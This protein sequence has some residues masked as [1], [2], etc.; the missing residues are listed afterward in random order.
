MYFRLTC[1]FAYL[2]AT[3]AGHGGISVPGDLGRTHRVEPGQWFE[4]R[5][6]VNNGGDQPVVASIYQTDY[7]HSADGQTRYDPAPSHKRSNAG[8][9]TVTP[10]EMKLAAGESVTVT[11]QGQV[12][13]DITLEGSFWSMIMIEG[14]AVSESDADESDESA[15]LRIR[16]ITRYGI[17]IGTHIG[18]TGTRQLKILRRDL[19]K[20]D[21]GLF[22]HLDVENT[23][24]RVLRPTARADLYT[25]DGVPWGAIDHPRMGI[26]PGC[27]VRYRLDMSDV[28]AGEYSALVVLDNGDEHVFGARY[29]LTVEP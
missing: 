23:G 12:P 5:I 26:Y 4:G 19:I 15:A 1:I 13:D 11:Y 7:H 20:T 14:R 28:P 17:Q 10:A 22:L 25:A 16:T 9:I 18:D 29:S 8:W 3:C 27:S 21:Q 24:T 6:T 2:A